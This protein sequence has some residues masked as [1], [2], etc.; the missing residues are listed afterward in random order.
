MY[1]VSSIRTNHA[2][3]IKK[4]TPPRTQLT[5]MFAK[6][7]S[8]SLT[9]GL[10]SYA[11]ASAAKE[12]YSRATAA[13]MLGVTFIMHSSARRKTSFMLAESV[14]AFEALE[15]WYVGPSGQNPRL[16]CAALAIL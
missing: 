11:R 12:G 14:P 9:E 8:R 2:F 7:S 15:R 16:A 3:R 13:E 10:D 1:D 4:E 5:S 6:S